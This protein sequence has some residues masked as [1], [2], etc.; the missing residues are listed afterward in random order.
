VHF[1]DAFIDLAFEVGGI[2]GLTPRVSK[3]IY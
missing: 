3:A 1:E 2:E